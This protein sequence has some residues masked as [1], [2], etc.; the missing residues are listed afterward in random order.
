MKT[1]LTLE[2]VALFGLSI[3]LFW[4]LP[5]AWWWYPVLILVPDVGMIG[6][7]V[8]PQMGAMTYNL[9]H[10]LA[11]GILCYVIGYFVSV[12]AL[13]MAGIIIIGHSALDRALGFG[14]KYPDAFKHTHLGML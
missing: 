4:L 9:T 1:L 10:W 7:L 5:F 11:L 12:P 6:Y 2:Y 14:L 3:F 8:S 13:E